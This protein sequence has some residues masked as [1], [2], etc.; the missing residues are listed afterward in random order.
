MANPRQ[1]ER[2]KSSS[3]SAEARVQNGGAAVSR[4]NRAAL[5]RAAGALR[6]VTDEAGKSVQDSAKAFESI[7]RNG[8]EKNSQAVQDIWRAGME[9]TQRMSE[10]AADQ[11]T[12]TFGISNG[13]A[14]SEAAEQSTRN[15]E[16]VMNSSRV[17]AEGMSHLSREMLEMTRNGVQRNLAGWNALMQCRTPHD[18]FA[19]HSA[20]IRDNLDEILKGSRRLSEVTVRVAEEAEQSMMQGADK[21]RAA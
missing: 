10:R 11:M 5:H 15:M 19:A 13:E 6:D 3:A 7:A 20:L 18:V 8:A 14:A 4:A 2:S 1:D 12:R 21:D 17:L 9:F 16:A